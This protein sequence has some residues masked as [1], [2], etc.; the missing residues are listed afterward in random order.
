MNTRR[1]A[2]LMLALAVTTAAVAAGLDARGW[3]EGTPAANAARVLGPVGTEPI[4][5]PFP[6][7]FMSQLKRTTF[8][9]YFSPTCPH[10]QHVAPEI[11][12][13]AARIGDRADVLGVAPGG[14][15]PDQIRAFRKAYGWSFPVVTDKDRQIVSAI[16][17]Q[18]TPSA[19]LVT[20]LNGAA[21]LV[22]LWYPY[23]PGTDT[24]VEMRVS[25]NPWAPFGP[26]EYHG[27]KTCGAC[28]AVEAE[29]WALSHHSVAWRTLVDDG[30]DKDPAC[31]GCHVTGAGQP[32][33]WDGTAATDRLTDVQCEACHGPGG[34]HDGVVTD[35]KTQCVNCHDAKHSIHFSYE[36]GL[37]LI[38][39]YAASELDDAGFDAARRKLVSGEAPRTL[40]AF[41]DGAYVGAAACLTCHAE[42]HAQWATSG[43]GRAM[44]P[45]AGKPS[46]EDASC[47]RCH[48]TRTQGGPPSSNVADYRVDEGVGCESCHGPGGAHVAAGGGKD[49]IVGLGE[50]C[51]VCVIE[52]VCTSC[53]TKDWSPEWDVDVDLPK[54][55]HRPVTGAHP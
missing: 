32:M 27:I 21:R 15:P 5:V 6:A 3:H 35:P 46:A 29:S 36:K 4:D 43:H 26:G 42:E 34:P 10:C 53:H 30:K 8:V 9:I 47:V 54:V 25:E 49:N 31:T 1:V 12:K 17:A 23:A 22:D 41:G 48:A 18:G 52:A 40:L 2:G 33:G 20:P 7:S 11:G 16:G 19:L 28:H 13:L 50:S 39:H 24:L 51:P 38:D 44:A 55:A 14:T 37:P 45:L